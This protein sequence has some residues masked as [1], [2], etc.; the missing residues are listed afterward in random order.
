MSAGTIRLTNNSTAVVGTGTTFTSDLKSGDVITA[1][2]GGVFYT[3]FVDTVTSNTAVTITDPFTGPTTTGV[4]YV[5]VPQLALNRITAAL[6]TQTA[7]AV[8]RILQ[9]N[10][11]WQAFYSGSGDITVTLPDGTPTGKQVS[12]PSWAKLKA[13]AGS[14]WQDRGPLPPDANLNTMAPATT[15]G[16]WGKGS[17]T[18]LN[19]A[20]GFPAGALPGVLKVVAGGRFGGT[21]IYTNSGYDGPA[22]IWVRSLTAAWNGTDG[23]WSGWSN[24]ATSSLRSTLLGNV[25]ISTL[26]NV[27]AFG[28]YRVAAAN[29]TVANGW[30]YEGFSGTLTVEQGYG[31]GAQQTAVSVYG[32]VYLRYLNTPTAWSAWVNASIQACPAYFTGNA[33]TLFDDGSYPTLAT[34]T[35][36]PA[37]AGLSSG[38]NNCR[39]EVRTLRANLC[40]TQDWYLY[41]SGAQYNGR[42]FTRSKYSTNPWTP[43]REVLDDSSIGIIYGIGASNSSQSGVDW[44]TFSFV[45]GAAYQISGASQANAPAPLNAFTSASLGVNILGMSGDPSSTTSIAWCLFQVAV[46]STG[47]TSRRLFNGVFRGTNGNRVYSILEVA[48]GVDAADTRSRLGLGGAAVL[49][50]GSA[51]GTVAAG[52]D[53]RFSSVN[54]MGGGNINGG[55]TL[56][57]IC[58]NDTYSP[59][60]QGAY[61][62]WNL[63]SSGSGVLTC[64]IGAG[65]AGGWVMRTVN[66]ANSQE[67]SRFT[68]ANTGIGYASGGW[69]TGSDIHVKYDVEPV[70]AALPAV[71]SLVGAQWKYKPRKGV[72]TAPVPG[73]GLIA[74]QVERFHP[75]AVTIHD[76]VTYFDD[77]TAL[78]EHKSLDVSGVSA[79]YHNEAIKALFGLVKLALD[80]P[81]AARQQI[82]DIEAEAQ[83]LTVSLEDL[84]REQVAAPTETPTAEE[85]G[86]SEEGNSPSDTSASEEKQP[87][88]QP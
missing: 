44:Q 28:S 30:P 66:Q 57:F 22:Y 74:Q 86:N 73:I 70:T 35:G 51:A 49:N 84:Q 19:E 36:L 2:V 46:Y 79:A 54:G 59:S 42:K 62:G 14:S 27:N 69:Q 68:L 10:A 71:L 7:E 1:T 13:D 63:G 87:D 34:T 32:N 6:A 52:N 60:N 53:P 33:D 55:I 43:W 18:G 58:A 5:A 17:S 23:P 67:M 31:S 15:E 25:D 26:N 11:N 45:N 4:S 47:G 82:A 37:V 85:P 83:A 3:L 20:N 76:E 80:D 77:G 8:R 16:E 50:V 29:G 38:V 78:P 61:L 39:L 9:E 21:Q 81:D 41:G 56:P 72:T 12:G 65:T 24:V 48:A 88:I 64:N 75:E 40:V